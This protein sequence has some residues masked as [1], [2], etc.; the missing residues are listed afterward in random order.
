MVSPAAASIAV[1]TDLTTLVDAWVNAPVNNPNYGIAIGGPVGNA[2]ASRVFSSKEGVRAPQLIIDYT[3]PPLRI[4]L[5]QT[6]TCPPAANAVLSVVGR[7][8][9]LV[10]NDQGLITDT[11]GL[12]LGQQVWARY[13]VSS[14]NG[15]ALFYTLPGP[16]TIDRSQFVFVDQGTEMRLAV[17]SQYPLWVQN[18]AVS[19]QWFVQADPAQAA[20]LRSRIISASNYLYSFT[21]GQFAL[22]DVVVQQVYD[23][24]STADIQLFANN[25]LQPKAIIGGIVPTDTADFAPTVPVTYTPG[26]VSIGSYWNRFGS[27][28][29][30]VN[31]FEGIAYPEA[32]VAD[33]WSLALA[34]EFG[35][36]LLYLYDT[37]TGV[38]GVADIALTKVCTGTAM[39]DVYL[40]SNQNFIF[41]PAHWNTGCAGTEAYARLKGRTE[42]QT[43]AGWYPWVI[44]PASAVAGPAAPPTP[45][46]NVLFLAPRSAPG[47]AA[48][49]LYNLDYRDN[50][51]SSGEARAFLYQ[52]DRIVEQGKPPRNSTIVRVTGAE[53]GDRLCVYDVNDHAETG[54]SPRNQFSCEV[55]AAGDDSLYMTKQP[56]W[57]PEVSLRQV[58]PQQVQIVV[59]S[60]LPG[61]AGTQLKARLYPEHQTAL[62]PVVLPR[63][64]NVFSTTVSLAQP[65]SALYVQVFVEEAP[66]LPLTRREIVA[67]R[68]TGGGGAFGPAKAYGG[69]LVVSSDGNASFEGDGDLELLPGQSIAW[70]SMPGTPPLPFFKLISGQAYRLDAFPPSLVENGTIHIKYEDQFGALTANGSAAPAVIHF[71]NGAVWTP[72]SSTLATPAGAADGT[73]VASAPSQGNGVYAVLRDAAAGSATFLPA[74]RTNVR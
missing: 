70:Q 60:T 50:E 4:C 43:I 68:G 26:S 38:D 65:V 46:T 48:A 62:A 40:P 49:Q 71:W 66:A 72:L 32:A 41:D 57:R 10:A 64:G 12:A 30:S 63:T 6:D 47:N 27:P 17:M 67:D 5:E 73:R 15:G 44:A 23:G 69:V 35:H 45:L 42:W 54:E 61:P 2:A 22:G 24:W 3:L 1:D 56:T 20:R 19:A 39:G 34:H 52:H 16:V 37:Y 36:F 7:P 14:T 29:D 33:D 53:I 58:G 25:T 55:L 31:V 21:D 8:N 18:L 28:P 9:V 11:V 59:T 74:V 13:E 51:L